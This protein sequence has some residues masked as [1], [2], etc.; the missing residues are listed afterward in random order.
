[1]AETH[2][3]KINM[4]KELRKISNS[5]FII[6]A[7]LFIYFLYRWPHRED[8][9]YDEYTVF[10]KIEVVDSALAILEVDLLQYTFDDNKYFIFK[11]PSPSN[12][13]ET[14]D[15]FVNLDSEQAREYNKSAYKELGYYS[16]KED[17]FYDAKIPQAVTN[18]IAVEMEKTKAKSRYFRYYYSISDLGKIHLKI[19][20]EFHGWENK[21]QKDI[22]IYSCDYQA[23]KVEMTDN[24]R[25]T[26]EKY[27]PDTPETIE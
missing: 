12:K 27:F 1:M 25:T 24:L 8:Y 2:G 17:L 11:S 16:F 5:Y 6:I 15:G 21:D 7:I 19:M 14:E 3:Y 26:L 23:R 20:E 9:K 22:F 4:E 13:I 10:A 18:E